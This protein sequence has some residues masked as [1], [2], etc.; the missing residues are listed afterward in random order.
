LVLAA[1]ALVVTVLAAGP[2]R[3]EAQ[4]PTEG[5]ATRLYLAYFGRNPDAGGL[6][7]WV[8]RLEAGTS[9]ATVSEG[10]ARSPEF[11]HTYGALG[12]R[13]FVDL[14]YRNVLGRAPDGGGRAHWVGVLATRQSTRGAVMVG[15]SESPEFV[16]KT[17]T[18]PPVVPPPS[19]P[20]GRPAVGQTP[21]APNVFDSADPS[22]LVVGGHAYLFGSTNNMKLPV[23][24]LQMSGSLAASQALWAQAPHDAMTQRPAWV[25]PAEWEIWA[26]AMV[27]LNGRYYVYFASHRVGAQDEH[28]DQCIGRAKATEPTGP[29]VPEP[30]PIYCGLAAELRSNTWGRGALDPEIVRTPTGQLYLLAALS[31]TAGNIGAVRLDAGGLVLGGPNAT[32]AVLVSQSL[33]YHDGSPD[34]TLGTGAFLENPA[35]VYD[36]ATRTYLLFY[37]AGQWNTPRYVTGFA[38]CQTPVGPC[39]TDPRGPF[40][41]SGNGRT[42]PGGLALFRDG[43]GTL[44]ALYATW[45]AGHEGEVGAVGEYK[46]QTH[47]ARLVISG[48]DV[49][50]QSVS[51]G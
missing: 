23:R 49:G 50:T 26:P 13:A 3:A 31:R 36:G 8:A 22:V 34:G 6:R 12:D 24:T 15:F 18:T 40:L 5:S 16:R 47:V 25:D 30:A 51:L 45:Q 29:Y 44:R 10:F 1:L 9:L 11:V 7:Y 2:G 17:G 14:V 27:T 35:M 20:L 42:G 4:T 32:P 46:R 21:N 39:T 37:S 33:D 19:T 28:N 48:S 38:R 41:Q 43:S